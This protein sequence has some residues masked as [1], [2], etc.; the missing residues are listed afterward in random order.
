MQ[1]QQFTAGAMVYD[2]AGKKVGTLHAYNPQSGFLAVRTGWLVRKDR[3]IHRSAVSR[4]DA[5]GVS[6]QLSKDELQ[7]ARYNFPWTH[8][9]YPIANVANAAPA[10]G[11]KRTSATE[12]SVPA[13]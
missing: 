5:A 7:A 6:L 9:E 8:I 11:A 3:Y 2:R 1:G 10:G 12:P 13:G 4:G